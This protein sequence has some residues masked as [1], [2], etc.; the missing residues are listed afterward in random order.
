MDDLYK[1]NLIV[2]VD[3]NQIDFYNKKGD[4]LSSLKVPEEMFSLNGV[5]NISSF[6]KL[7]TEFISQLIVKDQQ[8]LILLSHN[9]SLKEVIN[10][11]DDQEPDLEEILKEVTIPK[12]KRVVKQ[13]KTRDQLHIFVASTELITPLCQGFINQGWQVKALLP[14][15]VYSK[16]QKHDDFLS[17][18]TIEVILKDTELIEM[19]NMFNPKLV[20]SQTQ[21]K[22]EPKLYSPVLFTLI[23]VLLDCAIL[24]YLFYIVTYPPKSEDSI[25]SASTSQSTSQ[26]SITPQ[27]TKAVSVSKSSL[28]VK[29]LNGSGVA[30]Q[31]GQV[32]DQIKQLGYTNIEVG[33]SSDDNSS[34]T[35]VIFSNKVPDQY[36]SELITKLKQTFTKI[37]SKIDPASSVDITVTTGTY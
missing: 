29:V 28:K 18:K 32:R 2:F 33:N 8:V 37:D 7:L 13:L 26:P 19:A 34:T 36:Q 20:T 6:N 1:V 4:K 16:S 27:P 10:R 5:S 30:G 24:G 11:K 3:T 14:F 9:L 21:I 31:A 23:M 25:S 17:Q 12:S 22:K 15:A 35:M